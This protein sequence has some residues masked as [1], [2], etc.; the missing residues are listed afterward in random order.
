MV[1][2][3][4]SFVIKN[5]FFNDPTAQYALACQDSIDNSLKADIPFMMKI[6]MTAASPTNVGTFIDNALKTSSDNET[7]LYQVT[8][9]YRDADK[10]QQSII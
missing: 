1:S 6:N 10:Q 9:I 4:S 7:F 3:G 8:P 2:G 5:M